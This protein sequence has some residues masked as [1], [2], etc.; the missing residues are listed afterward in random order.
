MLKSVRTYVLYIITLIIEVS[1][2]FHRRGCAKYF[3]FKVVCDKDTLDKKKKVTKSQILKSNSIIVTT[4]I[5]NTEYCTKEKSK[6]HVMRMM[7]VV[8]YS[9]DTTESCIQDQ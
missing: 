5:V 7:E 1:V 2:L 3:N 8:C 9:G 4:Y 6:K